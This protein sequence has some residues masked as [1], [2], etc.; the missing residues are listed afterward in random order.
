VQ[1]HDGNATVRTGMTNKL[2]LTSL[3]SGYHVFPLPAVLSYL[4]HALN[5]LAAKTTG[6]VQQEALFLFLVD[7]LISLSNSI[8]ET[9]LL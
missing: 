2:H 8:Q 1:K 3:V 4:V 6:Q 7:L 5:E 9:I